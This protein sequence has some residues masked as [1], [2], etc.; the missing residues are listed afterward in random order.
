M[1]VSVLIAALQRSL[2][3]DGDQEVQVVVDETDAMH[4]IEKVSWD[5]YNECDDIMIEII[6]GPQDED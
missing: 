3:R 4:Q 5:V 2:D 6:V 1:K